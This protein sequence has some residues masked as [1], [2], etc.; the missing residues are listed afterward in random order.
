MPEGTELLIFRTI[1]MCLALMPVSVFAVDVSAMET[2]LEAL[3]NTAS[4]DHTLAAPTGYKLPSDFDFCQP[5]RQPNLMRNGLYVNNEGEIKQLPVPIKA[6]VPSEY[7]PVVVP[8][9]DKKDVE[10]QPPTPFVIDLSS[11]TH[12]HRNNCS[13]ITIESTVTTE[14][15]EPVQSLVHATPLSRQLR[16]IPP[17]FDWTDF[18]IFARCGNPDEADNSTEAIAHALQAGQSGAE[19]YVQPL[20]DGNGVVHHDL[21]LGRVSYRLMVITA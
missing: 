8:L 14:C 2:M 11:S 7:D 15:A 17:C 13:V 6:H 18:Q 5:Q 10:P 4:C 9:P 3:T 16:S 12:A 20:K 21:M 19:I 1:L